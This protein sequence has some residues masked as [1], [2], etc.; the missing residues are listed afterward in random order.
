MTHQRK[1]SE[2]VDT[3]LLAESIVLELLDVEMY[4][5]KCLQCVKYVRLSSKE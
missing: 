4:Y 5:L 1:E 2:I 3:Q